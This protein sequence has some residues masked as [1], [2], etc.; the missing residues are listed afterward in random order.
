MRL[1]GENTTTFPQRTHLASV[2]DQT[3]TENFS[4]KFIFQANKLTP[5]AGYKYLK[6]FM[7]WNGFCHQMDHG[8]WWCKGHLRLGLKQR[9]KG[10]FLLRFTSLIEHWAGCD[11]KFQRNAF[12]VKISALFNF[13]S[14]W[15]SRKIFFKWFPLL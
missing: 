1:V 12:P 13:E 3:N 6:S 5:Q 7:F 10:K 8:L 11:V 4:L 15:S 2:K 9:I 14:V